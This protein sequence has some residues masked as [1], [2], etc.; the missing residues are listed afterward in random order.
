MAEPPGDS[1]LDDLSKWLLE[2]Y[3]RPVELSTQLMGF[4]EHRGIFPVL[5]DGRLVGWSP[6]GLAAQHLART[7][8]CAKLDKKCAVVPSTLEI[9]LIAP[10]DTGSQYPGLYLFIGGSRL[11]RPVKSLARVGPD[12]IDNADIEMI[13]TFEQ[14][15]LDIAVT[16]AEL[17]ERRPQERLHFE[18]SPEHIFS[19]IASLTPFCDYNQVCFVERSLFILIVI[20]KL[21]AHF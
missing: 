1:V 4:E 12:E 16:K 17:M 3:V 20:H 21:P 13:G 5:L 6:S 9:C 15:Y 8:R 18:V 11:L 10:T 14:P 19:F 7:L 2:H